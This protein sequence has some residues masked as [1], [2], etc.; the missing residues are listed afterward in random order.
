[1]KAFSV[2]ADA[3]GVGTKTLHWTMAALIISITVIGIYAARVLTYAN[4]AVRPVWAWWMYQHKA[5]GFIVLVLVVIRAIWNVSQPRPALPA[6]TSRLHRLIVH[7]S[8]GSLYFLMFVV[9]IAGIGTAF[10]AHS[11][12]KFFGL[13]EFYGPVARNV[14]TMA[15]FK[16]AHQITAYTMLGILVIHVSAALIHH[17]IL[18]DYVLRRMLFTRRADRI[19]RSY[20]PLMR[21]DRAPR[22]RP[23]SGDG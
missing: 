21:P 22:N 4:V 12:N 14:P 16:L 5:L 15:K 9:P 2:Q 6:G 19:G 1:M 3:W 7:V 18:K 11:L 20:A 23:G 8:V 13:F 17:F 10:Y